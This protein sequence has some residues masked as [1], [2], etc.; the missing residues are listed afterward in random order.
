MNVMIDRLIGDGLTAVHAFL[1]L[2][3]R[4]EDETLEH[5]RLSFAESFQRR[6]VRRRTRPGRERVLIRISKADGLVGLNT[7]LE[8]HHLLNRDWTSGA[9]RTEIVL[10]RIL[11]GL[12][13]WRASQAAQRIDT[14]RRGRR[15]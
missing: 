15:K 10:G 5:D 9:K 3:C 2:L 6:A 13:S 4:L 14:R 12:W 8:V 1:T 7:R 11:W